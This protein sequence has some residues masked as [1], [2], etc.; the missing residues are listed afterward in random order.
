MEIIYSGPICPRC[1]NNQYTIVTY[2]T[3]DYKRCVECG[4]TS[5]IKETDDLIPLDPQPE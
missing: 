5:S 2:G 4:R 1:I 3:R